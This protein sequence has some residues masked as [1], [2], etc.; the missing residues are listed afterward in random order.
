MRAAA[1][2]IW[3]ARLAS[4]VSCRPVKKE[5]NLLF[6]L[7]PEVPTAPW[8]SEPRGFSPK[9]SHPRIP[10]GS[11]LPTNPPTRRVGRCL[12]T[13]SALTHPARNHGTAEKGLC[14]FSVPHRLGHVLAQLS[15]PLY[16]DSRSRG[17]ADGGVTRRPV[18]TPADWV[19][20]YCTQSLLKL[21]SDN[22]H[23]LDGTERRG[24]P[25]RVAS[26]CDLARRQ[27]GRAYGRTRDP[28]PQSAFLLRQSIARSGQPPGWPLC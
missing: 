27:R 25:R 20:R 21:Q 23:P 6:W 18:A 22:F 12:E 3:L 9:D 7:A 13:Y 24:E 16:D 4:C 28:S 1:A 11:T 26:D 17:C 8:R 2:E 10:Q 15:D 19:M 5:T 14:P